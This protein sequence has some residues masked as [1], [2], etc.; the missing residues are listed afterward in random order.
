MA[1]PYPPSYLQYS[2]VIQAMPPHYHGQVTEFCLQKN[3]RTLRRND[4]EVDEM[5]DFFLFCASYKTLGSFSFL[6]S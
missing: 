5:L 1:S 2:Q 4:E 6:K 3:M